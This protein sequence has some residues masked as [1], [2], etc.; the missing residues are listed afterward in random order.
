MV[1][2]AALAS[3]A[4]H[5]DQLPPGDEERFAGYGVMGLPFASGHVL[6]MRRFPSS[7]IGPAYTSVWHREPDG[8]WVFWQDRPA[9]EGCARYFSN[10]V[11]ETNRVD[12]E[13]DWPSED[14]LRLRIP[15]A[16]F[17]WTATMAASPVTRALNAVGS[18]MPD[19]AWKAKPVL[20]A[21]G[22]AAG[23]AL[24]AGR[25]GMVG[26]APNGQQFI[27]NPLKIWLVAETNATL[28]GTEFGPMGALDPQPSLGEFPIP[29][30]GVFVM[31]RAFF[32]TPSSRS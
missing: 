7:S 25:V 4:E 20:S 6:A 1:D 32:T 29:N 3:E 18:V 17:E 10:A 8:R 11:S 30:R 28:A 9:G 16:D 22:P 24:R 14:T 27:A 19:S 12:I 23:F 31:G 13:L 21:M 2:L 15:D 26:T 5:R